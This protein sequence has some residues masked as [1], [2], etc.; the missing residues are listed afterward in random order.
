MS[1][2]NPVQIIGIGYS[3]PDSVI[4]NDDLST[5]METDDEWI[6]SRTGIKERRVVSED[7]GATSLSVKASEDALSY[8]GL[9]S[10]DLDLIISATSIPDYLYPS[11][12][13]EI[14][15]SIGA[16]NAVAFNVS[17]ACSGFIYA[18]KIAYLFLNSGNY[19][20]A[21]ITGCD[22]HSRFVDWNDR[23]TSILFGDAAGA[24]IMCSNPKSSN[25]ILSINIYSDGSKSKYLSLPI[26]GKNAPFVQPNK[27]LKQFVSM[28][29]QEI[30]KFSVRVI[31]NAI[32]E[33]L[34]NA[35]LSIQDMDYLIPH[36]ANIRIINSLKQKLGLNDSQVISKLQYLGNTSASSIPI[37]LLYSIK[38]KQIKMPSTL[39]M[40]GFGAGLTW[41]VAVIQANL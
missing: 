8:C 26:S 19:R 22:I 11:T 7:E 25:Q 9:G 5:I 17:A 15:G 39:V 14:Q 13:C 40:V 32:L 41:G 30:Y 1:K 23:N 18:I 28:N 21:L 35:G 16:T 10:K 37:A 24:V 38:N 20:C 3:I 31:P 12:A 29:G 27:T 6:T 36:Q 33:A 34:K 2:D 4:T